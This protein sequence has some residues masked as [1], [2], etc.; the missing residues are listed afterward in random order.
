MRVLLTSFEPFGGQAVNSS[1]EVGR[2]LSGSSIPG[3]DLERLTLPVVAR[4]CV[5]KAWQHIEQVQPDLVIALGQSAQAFAVRLEDIAL[6]IDDFSQPDNAGNQPKNQW[7]VPGAP[8]AYRSTAPIPRL[9][10]R[11]AER[12]TAHEHSFHAGT[13]VCNHLYYGLLHRAQTSGAAH[14]TLFVHLPLLPD[15]YPARARLPNLTLE[16]L[17]EA[18]RQVMLACL[19]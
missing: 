15:Q 4:A 16:Q 6:N 10:A 11:L 13:Y 8:L 18:V 3:V 2:A 1:L 14:R 17:V 5:E 7:I 19:E 9:L 12:K